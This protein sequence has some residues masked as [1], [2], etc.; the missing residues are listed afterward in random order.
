MKNKIVIE[1][2][3]KKKDSEDDK[4]KIIK[5]YREK[6]CEIRGEIVYNE[7]YT[8]SMTRNS[9]KNILESRCMLFPVKDNFKHVC[10]GK[11][12]CRWCE[13]TSNK[14]T[15][16]HV[17]WECRNSPMYGRVRDYKCFSGKCFSGEISDLVEVNKIYNDYSSELL[18]RGERY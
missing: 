3:K 17:L 16:K 15:E 10:R 6:M 4:N 5:N 9:V 1:A 7:K 2:K 18:K 8:T 13:N 14:E 11:V 12:V